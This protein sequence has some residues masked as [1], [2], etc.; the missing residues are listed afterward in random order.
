M[1][2][3]LAAFCLCACVCRSVCQTEWKKDKDRTDKILIVQLGCFQEGEQE[4]RI[5][6]K[7]RGASE[8]GKER[9]E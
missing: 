3:I 6:D 9:G 4:N 5:R 2:K 1:M 8:W 7:R